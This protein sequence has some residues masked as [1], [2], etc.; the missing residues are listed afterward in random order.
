MA[1]VFMGFCI[2][3]K[4]EPVDPNSNPNQSNT[5]EEPTTYPMG[6]LTGGE[7]VFT[8]TSAGGDYALP[9]NSLKLT[10]PAG[11]VGEPTKITILTVESTAPAGTGQSFRLLP[12]NVA[13][14]KPVTVEF[15]YANVSSATSFTQALGLAYQDEKGFW[16][17]AANPVVNKAK[18][19]VSVSTTHFSDWTLAHWFLLLPEEELTPEGG[20]V[21][22]QVVDY[23]INSEDGAKDPL[24]SPRKDLFMRD[25][26]PLDPRYIKNGGKG[27]AWQVGGPG[28]VVGSGSGATY[29]APDF[30][31]KPTDVSVSVSLTDPTGGF[32][33]EYL[34]VSSIKV[35]PK[36]VIAFR[37]GSGINT[38]WEFL[39]GAV[40]TQTA[41]GAF[42][43]TAIDK[44]SAS[45]T[46]FRTFTI[47]WS[48]GVGQ[49]NWNSRSDP[50]P[51]HPNLLQYVYLFSGT[52]T[53]RLTISSWYT[54]EEKG[55]VDGGGYVDIE[56]LP[57]VGSYVKGTFRVN[58]A[59]MWNVSSNKQEDRIFVEGYFVAKRAL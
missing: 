14:K 16:K 4:T 22:L 56:E 52:S 17:F 32:R 26:K 39:P 53:P 36:S 20:T 2:A 34:L 51:E 59:G 19:T 15:S 44:D 48:G 11:A 55:V 43:V 30:V 6:K 38:A 33:G 46:L 7:T 21:P 42:G 10:I 35:T 54:N 23:F 49:H 40:V 5:P 13:F 8:V 3:C 18:K 58:T 24:E 31:R 29:T 28:T 45:G 57:G 9:D 12:H 41:S 1:W 27:T 37:L 47:L 25:A 50:S